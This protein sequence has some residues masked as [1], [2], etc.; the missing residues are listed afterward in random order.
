MDYS[1]TKVLYVEDEIDLGNVTRQY[2]ELMELQVDWSTAAKPALESFESASPAYN[3]IIIDIQLPDMDGFALAEKMLQINPDVYLIFLTARKE[4]ADR[5][6]GLR[7]GAVNY[8]TKPFDVD[9][10]VLQLQNMLKH[11]QVIYRVD[12]KPQPT[13]TILIGDMVL[14]KSVLTLMLPDSQ[15]IALTKREAD[16]LEYFQL[17]QGKVLKRETILTDLWGDNDY[18]LGRSLDVFISR[19]RK[20]LKNSATVKIENVYGIGFIFS[21]K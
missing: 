13:E 16:L 12:A 19:L 18:F 9:E 21:I 3:I 2:L 1:N 5:L 10:L 6:K 20:L 11:Q 14:K 15:A 8:I 4:K 17:N 7:M